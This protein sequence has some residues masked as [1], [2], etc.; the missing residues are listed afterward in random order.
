[1]SYIQYL[2]S[3]FGFGFVNSNHKSISIK[4]FIDVEVIVIFFFVQG[5]FLFCVRT[6]IDLELP[7]GPYYPLG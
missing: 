6:N 7:T 2:R 1:M 5:D 4:K 3:F